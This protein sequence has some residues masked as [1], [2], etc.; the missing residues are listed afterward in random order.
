VES[1]ERHKAALAN[2]DSTA[3]NSTK[4]AVRASGASH[5]SWKLKIPR[6]TEM[7]NPEIVPR[8]KPMPRIALRSLLVAIAARPMIRAE[9]ACRMNSGP[10]IGMCRYPP[11]SQRWKWM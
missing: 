8:A 4:K 7:R 6:V 11:V 10:I 3:A 9:T 5:E 1:P 2:R